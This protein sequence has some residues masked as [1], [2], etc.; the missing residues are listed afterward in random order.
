MNDLTSIFTGLGNQ[1][2]EDIGFWAFVFIVLASLASAF[3]FSTLYTYFF[4]NR[5]TGS[6]I[7][8]AFPLLSISITVIF[9]TIQFSLPLSLG[10]LGALSIVRFRTPIKE[11]E[12]IGFIMLVVASSLSCATFNLIF[13]VVLGVVSLIALYIM[14]IFSPLRRKKTAGGMLV[15]RGPRATQSHKIIKEVQNE[16]V[17]HL[18]NGTLQSISCDDEISFTYVFYKTKNE[19][20]DDVV[21]KL[22]GSYPQFQFNVMMNRPTGL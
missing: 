1:R 17:S 6:Q 19:N 21:S 14:D 13:P 7:H 18:K 12:E 10:L 22:I 16:I 4:A 2:M 8:R 5:A 15:V 11:P 9:I 20:I 3:V